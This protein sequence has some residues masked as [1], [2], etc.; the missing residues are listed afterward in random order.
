MKKFQYKSYSENDLLLMAPD[1]G[2]DV[3]A[4]NALGQ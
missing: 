2:E 4:L 3:T 1:D